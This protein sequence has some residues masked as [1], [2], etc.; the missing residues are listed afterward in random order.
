MDKQIIKAFSL[1]INGL[2]SKKKRMGFFLW[3]KE[4][5]ADI[6]FLQETHCHNNK[7]VKK[8]TREWGPRK[9]SIWSKGSSN[10]KGV[11]VLFKPCSNLCYEEVKIDTCGRYIYFDLKIE[12][13]MHRLLNIYAPNDNYERIKFFQRMRD[14][15]DENKKNWI[16]GDYNCT[17]DSELD[18]LNCTSKSDV[19]Q[20]DIKN[21]MYDYGL[22]EIYRRRYPDVK[23]YSWR[24][25]NKQSRLDYW[26][27]SENMDSHIDKVEYIPCPFSDHD[28]ASISI[29]TTK[30]PQGPGIWK[31]NLEVINSKLFQDSFRD[32]WES[33][34]NQKEKYDLH[35]WW[36]LGK[37][38]IK[39][40]TIWC[41]SKL[42]SDK[43]AIKEEINLKLVNEKSKPD[44]NHERIDKLEADLRNI[45]YKESEG[46]KIS[47]KCQWFEEGEKPTKY[48]HNLEKYHGD[49][50]T[51][52]KILDKN[53]KIVEGT[54]QIMR[55][56]T[57]FYRELYNYVGVDYNKRDF[58]GQFINQRLSDESFEI[59]NQH[60]E[61]SEVFSAIKK[62]KK[63]S[64]PGPDGIL[65]DF[66]LLFWETIKADLFQLYEHSY[67][68]RQMAY[69]QY[70]ALIILLY[71]KGQREDIRNWRP[72]SLCNTD[73]KIV[74]KILAERAKKVLP[75]IINKSQTGCVKGRKIG[76]S[77]RFIED[78]LEHMDDENIILLVDQQKAFDRIEWGWLFY[79]LENYGFGQYF[80]N[81]IKILYSNMKSAIVTNGYVSPYFRVTRGIRQGDS[82]SALLYVIQSEALAECIRC[83]DTIKGISIQ[84][85]DSESHELKGTQ[86]VD[87]ATHTLKSVSDVN[88]CL[89]TVD[90]FGE[91]SGSKVNKEKTVAL[92]SEN[93]KNKCDLPS[94]IKLNSGMEIILGAPI[95]RRQDKTSFWDEKF[96]KMEKRI[97]MW[98]T[99]D[100]SMFGKVHVTKSLVLPLIQFAG[101][102]VDMPDNFIKQVQKLIWSFIW[103]WSTCFVNKRLCSLPRISGGIGVPNVDVMIKTAKIKMVV[104]ILKSHSDWNLLA[105]KY[106]CCL[107]NSYGIEYFALLVTDSSNAL[108]KCKIP[109]YYRKCILAIQELNRKGC[110]EF[111]NSIV[112]CN[113]KFR[114]NGKVLEHKHWSKDGIRYLSDIYYENKLNGDVIKSKLTK[115]AGFF[116]EFARLKK[117]NLPAEYI[118]EDPD[119]SPSL[120][121][122]YYNI[123]GKS[124][125][126]HLYDLTSAEIYSILIHGEQFG[127]KSEV[128]W[129]QK[130]TDVTIDFPKLYANLFVS[131][132]TPRD[133]LDFNWRV[134]NGQFLTEK[135]LRTLKLSNGI[136]MCCDGNTI[137]DIFHLFVE[138]SLYTPVWQYVKRLIFKFTKN[139]NDIT[140]FHQILGIQKYT[141]EYLLVNMI[142]GVTR[143][144][145]WKSR[146]RIKYN[147][148]SIVSADITRDLKRSL[149]IH[150]DTLRNGRVNFTLK[151]LLCTLNNCLE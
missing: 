10:S 127:R 23:K 92:V 108:E 11:A 36:D 40:L 38:K 49:N 25:G 59:L 60:I 55:I 69:S 45:A 85:A 112:W 33:W 20:I 148:D 96:D 131:K 13:E 88:A 70:L 116:F 103:K 104:E 50:K 114:F 19:G 47:S 110:K 142:L 139:S 7:D 52:T 138:C 134:F 37:K 81:W 64:S 32:I 51:W 78:V 150:V 46:V 35:T 2:R 145:I 100:L 79:V 105:K 115:K 74:S 135:K 84:G 68:E 5:N 97:K 43:T 28:I 63:G 90:Q 62:M 77:I 17:I 124:M 87:D 22:E 72:I 119:A 76:H 42:K 9:N 140:E 107:D 44:G 16:G 106:M 111:K 24:R 129:Q 99:R 80:I 56:Q 144:I 26:L 125:A 146:C 143:W 58:F 94:E 117:S 18:R 15:I 91:A 48:F 89:N 137:E 27:V 71:K 21:I 133:V 41:S 53:K 136:C 132:I 66:Y 147:K 113:D 109:V 3:L 101:A 6:I 141:A 75:E 98:K 31:M 130:F 67:T 126:K 128:Y 12:D 82:L 102:Q 73:V 61:I 93:F 123:P 34:V 54:D 149:R 4:L 120:N 86:Y 57:D 151:P 1:N 118:I 30:I 39:K 83:S 65:I 121:N 29:D 122:L 14:W 95:S 8:W